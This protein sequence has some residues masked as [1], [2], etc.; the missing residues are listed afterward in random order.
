MGDLRNLRTLSWARQLLFRKGS[1]N[2]F[3]RALIA[4]PSCMLWATADSYTHVAKPRV[5]CSIVMPKRD[6]FCDSGT[7]TQAKPQDESEHR[8]GKLPAPQMG[9]QVEFSVPNGSFRADTSDCKNK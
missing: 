5:A 3:K 9:K 6:C 4:A 1:H 8:V 7:S 2:H